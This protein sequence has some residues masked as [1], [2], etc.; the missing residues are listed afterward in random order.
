MCDST[1]AV[2]LVTKGINLL[3]IGIAIVDITWITCKIKDLI[4]S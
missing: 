1:T 2:D 4:W 3:S